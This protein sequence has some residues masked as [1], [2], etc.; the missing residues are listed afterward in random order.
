MLDLL[1]ISAS[2][3]VAQP[4]AGPADFDLDAVI[5]RQMAEE[6]DDEGRWLMPSLIDLPEE[7][8]GARLKLRG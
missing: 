1:I 2:L 6:V 5:D 4:T 3:A 7:E 8:E